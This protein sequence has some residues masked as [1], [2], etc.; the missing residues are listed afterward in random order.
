MNNQSP[1]LTA[2]ALSKSF[3]TQ[4]VLT[5]IDYVFKAPRTYALMGVSGTGKS[6]L[7]HMLAGLDSPD[8]GSVFTTEKIACLLQSPLLIDEL[9]VL[10]NVIIQGLMRSS[11]DS[12]PKGEALLERVGL[13]HKAQSAPRTLSGGEQQRVAL[14]RALFSEP[15]FIVADEPTAHLDSD[16]KKA[17]LDLLLEQN[18]SLIIATH[19]PEV[20]TRMETILELKE[21]KLHG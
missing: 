10:E 19:D 7:I 18:R 9:T 20:A 8:A 5:N 15:T 13:T 1:T 12:R 16:S 4:Q 11:K 2:H 17:M 21:G 14:A 6:T 3:G